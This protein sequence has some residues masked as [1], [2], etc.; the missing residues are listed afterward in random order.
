MIHVHTAQNKRGLIINCKL[1][2]H[3]CTD[4]LH[5][6]S[7]P[8]PSEAQRR[9][10]RGPVRCYPRLKST[11]SAIRCRNMSRVAMPQRTSLR[12]SRR[13]EDGTAHL[14]TC[15]GARSM[16]QNGGSSS[17][18]VCYLVISHMINVAHDEH[19]CR[20]CRLLLKL[21]PIH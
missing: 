2:M 10:W 13:N 12:K 1:E 19:S 14:T 17:T 7:K 15:T 8:F 6:P 20:T 9:S 5:A 3:G 16:L 11:R 21:G 18:V 4:H